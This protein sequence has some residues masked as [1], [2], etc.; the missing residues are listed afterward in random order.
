MEP[1][2]ECKS[3][4]AL[5]SLYLLLSCLFHFTC[6]FDFL[7]RRL[8]ILISLAMRISLEPSPSFCRFFPI[9]YASTG[10]LERTNFF[11]RIAFPES[12][13]PTSTQPRGK[14]WTDCRSGPILSVAKAMLPQVHAAQFLGK[15]LITAFS[16]AQNSVPRPVTSSK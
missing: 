15:T 4:C 2:P 12:C 1:M 9:T 7:L 13:R 10:R 14:M 3:I 16:A 8:S 5:F 11:M 6:Y